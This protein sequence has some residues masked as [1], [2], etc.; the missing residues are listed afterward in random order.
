MLYRLWEMSS[1]TELTMMSSLATNLPFQT[2]C[3]LLKDEREW[4]GK[5]GRSY[6][7]PTNDEPWF[8]CGGGAD[9]R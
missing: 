8:P 2:L 1:S 6:I 3:T 5:S 9:F 4:D 7:H